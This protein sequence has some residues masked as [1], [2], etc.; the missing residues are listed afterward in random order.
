V[1][2]AVQ[3][4][5]VLVFSLHFADLT[6]AQPVPTPD[7]VSNQSDAQ[8]QKLEQRARDKSLRAPKAL[9]S[10]EYGQVVS[11]AHEFAAKVAGSDN[12]L[13]TKLALD[14]LNSGMAVKRGIGSLDRAA[15]NAAAPNATVEQ[16]WAKPA[17]Q[18]N[19]RDLLEKSSKLD[20]GLFPITGPPSEFRI[21]GPGT[22]DVPSTL[23]K[24]CV[25]VGRRV[26]GNDQFCCTGTLVGKNVVVTAGH[27]FFCTG[28]GA[29]STAVAFVGE[30]TS[31]PGKRYTGKVHRHPSYNSGGLH[32]D[33]A[34]IVLDVDVTDVAPRR[35]ATTAEV[36]TATFVRAAGFGNSD[37]ASSTGFGV[38]RMVDVPVDSV[39][40]CDGTESTE[41]GCDPN[42]EMVAGFVGLGPDSCNGDSGGPVYLLVGAD[43][44]DDAAWVVAGATSR[45]TDL[46][47]RPCGDGGVYARLD[48]FDSFIRSVPGARF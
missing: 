34:V 46:A 4:A 36:N 29:N 3:I 5:V 7:P 9:T 23:L 37:F 1:R 16:I 2:N 8:M 27:C 47:T 28:A 45:A 26:G 17:L 18:K 10:A 32:N 42:L 12:S 15:V 6:N 48:A 40:C 20:A 31:K 22:Q 21:V 24:D 41:L 43:A 25:C 35:M 14:A 30:D 19:F 13:Y 44:R 39:C 33:L 38:K 11:A